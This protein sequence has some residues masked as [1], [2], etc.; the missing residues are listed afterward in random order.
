MADNHPLTLSEYH[1]ESGLV[2]QEH[3]LLR[4]KFPAIDFHGHFGMI[5]SEPY[6]HM[7]G[8]GMADIHETVAVL[9]KH[10]IQRAVN[11]DGLWD[12]FAGITVRGAMEALAATPDF[13]LTFV[14]VDTRRAAEPGFESMVRGHLLDAKALGARGIKLFKHVSL[15]VEDGRGGFTPGR[16]LRLDDPRLKVIWA[17]AEELKLPVLVHI[18]DPEAFFRPVD[19]FN[20][21]YEELLT[22]QDWQYAKP[23]LYTF[24][25][26]LEMQ[27]ALLQGNPGTSFVIAHGGS[28]PENL[29]Y[30]GASLEKYPN[31]HIDIAERISEFGRQPYRSREFFLK[32]QDRILFGTD[33]Y[34]INMD[35]RYPPYFR[36]LETWDEYFDYSC[37]NTR[38]KIYGI[39]LPDGVLRKVYYKNALGLLGEG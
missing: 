24:Q 8:M 11:L 29:D 31:M 25:E 22:H 13:F 17:T 38:W 1:P 30:V 23:G 10:G 6:A 26:C 15:M 21:R 39:G 35:R 20:E 32:W 33:A 12:G 19:R 14:S 36:F 2:T 9:R 18:G 3:I 34:P 27:E 4:P 7:H 16:G 28:W 5:Y 37:Y